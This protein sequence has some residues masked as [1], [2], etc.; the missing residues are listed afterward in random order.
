MQMIGRRSFFKRLR[1]DRSGLAMVESAFA[2]PFFVFAGLCGVELANY[3]ITMMKVNQ[4][5]VLIAD[6]ASRV[7]DISQLESRRV[8]ESDIND[9][10]IGADIQAGQKLEFFNR[11]RAIISSLEVVPGSK[12]GEQYIH[13]QRCR[14]DK[15]WPSNYGK[16]G[17]RLGTNGMGPAGKTVIAMDGG[18]VIFV[19]I[20]YDYKTLI[21]PQL[22]SNR[23]ISAISTFTVRDKRDISQIYQR[24]PS[25]PDAVASCGA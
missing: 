3:A 14:G 4:L 1:R 15:T 24:N 22:I 21:A 16:A 5:A 17:D 6:N 12:S 13:W 10:L 20:A 8:Y 11:G 7:G 9:V 19:E 18:A 25:K 23:T 2:L